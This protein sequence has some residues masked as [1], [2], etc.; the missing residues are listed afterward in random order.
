[1]YPAPVKHFGRFSTLASG[2]FST[3]E[4]ERHQRLQKA[5]RDAGFSGPAEAAARF[6]WN[7][8][9][10][11]SNENGNA[12]FSYKK[13]EAFAK[14]FGV[15]P[16]WL[17]AGTG[18]MR[19]PVERLV[20]VIGRVGA[21]VTRGLLLASGDQSHEWVP[22]PPGGSA[23]AAA[24]L[25]Q[26]ESMPDVAE[27]GALLY[28]EDQRTPPTEDMIGKVV[29]VETDDDEVLVKRLQ[30]GSR[31]GL[32][33]LESIVGG[34]LKDVRVRWAARITTTVAAHQVRRIIRVMSA[35]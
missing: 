32:Y 35:A 8:N 22:A 17:Y 7:A 5:R 13:A 16:D 1:M 28:F 27:D 33:N 12:P 31:K 10:Y 23:R 18:A 24:V 19:E 15:R 29:I 21:N 3:M 14:A 2:R 9:T 30:R 4:D 25:V 11:K 20:P 6:G 26:G 34:T